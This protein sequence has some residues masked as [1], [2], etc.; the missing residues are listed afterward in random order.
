MAEVKTSHPVKQ[1][2]KKVNQILLGAALLVAMIGIGFFI[3]NHQPK[4]ALLWGLGAAGGFILQRSRFCFTAALR[5]PILTGSTSLAKALVI[6]ISTATVGFAV[7]QFIASVKG[8]TIPGNIEPVG[9]NTIVGAVL[10]GIGMVIAGGCAS[11]TLMRVGEGF[12]LQII[13]LVFFLAGS[14]WG[15]R[16]FGWWSLNFVSEKGVFL[17]EVFGWPLAIAL[18]FALLLLVFRVARW[19]GNR[20]SK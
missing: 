6:A 16:D 18:Q 1:K 9:V 17:P 5:D 12:L 2:K 3:A 13:V 20:K 4:S 14:L 10:F 15:A 11:G 7:L 8:Q 19:F